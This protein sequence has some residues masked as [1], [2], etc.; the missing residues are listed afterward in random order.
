M[1]LIE[2]ASAKSVWRGLDYYENNYVIHWD[3]S[4]PGIINGIVRG[5]ADYDVHVEVAHPRKSTCTCPFAAGRRVVC[6]HMIA[7]YFTAY[8]QAVVD[9]REDIARWEAEEEAIQQQ[10]YQDLKD[11]VYSLSKSELRERYLDLL[12]EKENYRNYN[13]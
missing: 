9:F 10:H 2:T 6:K 13:Y 4:D 3:E 5:T 12:I 1:G 11:Y 7:L 8:P